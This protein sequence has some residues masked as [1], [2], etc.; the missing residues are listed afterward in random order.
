MVYHIERTTQA[1]E[2]QDG[3]PKKILGPKR[4]EVTGERT[5][6]YNEEL[7]YLWSSPNI[8]RGTKSR[9]MGWVGHVERM[10]DRRHAYR[11]FMGRPDGKRPLGRRRHRWEPN[12]KIRLRDF[13]VC[14]PRCAVN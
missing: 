13:K 9:R 3:M 12:I 2:V 4:D 5:R 8:A 7:H 11:I 6:L 1:E 14:H 10:G